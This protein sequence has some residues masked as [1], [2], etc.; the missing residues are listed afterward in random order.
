[1]YVVL[2]HHMKLS[3]LLNWKGFSKTNETISKCISKNL[4]H[5][6]YFHY[7]HSFFIY[8]IVS[9]SQDGRVVS[10]G[11]DAHPVGAEYHLICT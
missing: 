10:Q 3:K 4:A 8:P 7:G 1:M 2:L 9:K 5:L 6:F 11:S